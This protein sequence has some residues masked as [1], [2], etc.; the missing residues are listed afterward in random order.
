MP[1]KGN[2]LYQIDIRSQKKQPST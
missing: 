1:K 2:I